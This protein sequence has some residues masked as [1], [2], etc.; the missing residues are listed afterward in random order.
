[1]ITDW[2]HN[3]ADELQL[4]AEVGFPPQS[5]NILFNG[6][7]VDPVSGSGSYNKVKLTPKKKHLLRL[8]NPSAENHFTV[9]MVGHPFTVIATDLVP[10][11][12]VVKSQL[13]LGVGQRYDVIID[14][15][16]EVDNYW[17]NVTLGGGGLCGSTKGEFPAA[18][19]SYEGAPDALPTNPGTPI[20]ADCSDSKGFEPIIVRNLDPTTFEADEKH[21]DV[22]LTQAV[23][24]RGNVFQW[25]VNNSAIDIEW[26]KPILQ[27]IAEKNFSF[28][29]AANVVELTRTEG[30]AYVVINNLAGIVSPL[31]MP[32]IATHHAATVLTH[33]LASPY[34]LAR[35]RFHGPGL[36]GHRR[37]QLRQRQE[38][39]ELHQPS[40]PRCGH[41]A[42]RLAS[43]GLGNQQPWG[44]DYALPYCMAC[45]SGTQ[46]TVPGTQR[47]NRDI[48]AP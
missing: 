21:L 20:T 12:P 22:N 25:T 47:Q 7:N 9:S 8:V 14:A 11:K 18:I 43:H 48:H 46:R 41:V 4:V 36:V 45:Q 28:P 35:P 44:L 15:S 24:S 23:T 33:P 10:V 34:S 42:G 29:A 30:W 39:V 19:F 40:P 1:V 3:T 17:F 37:L 2:Y 27:Y 31:L 38:P 32:P 16:E 5:D 6:T 13:F 26:D